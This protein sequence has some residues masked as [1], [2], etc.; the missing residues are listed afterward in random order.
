MRNW[1]I[2]SLSGTCSAHQTELLKSGLRKFLC[3]GDV[4]RRDEID[5]SH[6][7]AFHQMEGVKIL[8]ECEGNQVGHVSLQRI[9]R[10]DGTGC[11]IL[12]CD[13]QSERGKIIFQCNGRCALFPFEEKGAG[14]SSCFSE[15]YCTQL[16][17]LQ[18]DVAAWDFKSISFS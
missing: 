14:V 16:S 8:K 6:Y 13:Y 18:R 1:H 3:T 2:F 4:Y 17:E 10:R 12:A 7:P 15:V 5:A 9:D 11:M